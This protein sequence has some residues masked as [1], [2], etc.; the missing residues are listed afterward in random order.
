MK[1][2]IID[3]AERALFTFLQTFLGLVVLSGTETFGSDL[4]LGFIES[5]A[6][7]SLIAA[8]SVVKGALASRVNGVSP[9]SLAPHSGD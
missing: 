4:N 8:L 6:T 5:A 3:T 1:A 2:W 7:S 9:A